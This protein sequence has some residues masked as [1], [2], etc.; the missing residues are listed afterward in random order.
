MKKYLVFLLIFVVSF[1][2]FAQVKFKDLPNDHWAASAVYDLVKLGVTKGYPDGTFRGTKKITRYETAVFLSKLAKAIAGADI[3]ADIKTLKDEIAV[4]KRG[5]AG[6]PISGSY[7]GNLKFAN[8]LSS[9]GRGAVA[10]YRLMLSASRNLG[11]GADVK[12]NLDTM[13]YGYYN[14]G[15]TADLARNLLDLESNLKLDLAALGWVD[16]VDL[17]LTYGPGAVEHA[18]DSSGILPSEAGIVYARPDTEIV[19]SSSLWGMDVAGGYMAKGL[20]ASGRLTLSQITGAIGYT[21]SS[22]PLVKSLRFDATGEYISS[23]MFSSS[24]RDMRATFAFAAPLAEKVEASGTLGLGGSASSNMMVAGSVD[25]NDVWDTGTVASVRV[26][27]V[28]SQ[29]IST[30]ATFSDAEFDA[31]GLDV[32]DRA[33]GNGTINLGGKVTQSVSDDVTLVG[34]GEVRL[35]SNYAYETPNGRLTAEGGIS[36]GIAPDTSL[37]AMYRIDQD[38]SSGDTTDV[39]ALGLLYNF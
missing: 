28:G 2:A 24:N 17:K 4:L 22:V 12:I 35:N 16:P 26:A 21:F 36:Y 31:A 34:K 15:S 27:R 11:E 37:D 8:V 30:N 33:L 3:K 25:L 14:D 39:A 13:D 19:A 32:F 23:G 9:S 6:L 18:A 10:N 20:A 29:F 38:R 7:L 1:P 5:G